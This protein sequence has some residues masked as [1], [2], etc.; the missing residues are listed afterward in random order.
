M[1]ASINE[2]IIRDGESMTKNRTPLDRHI[3]SSPAEFSRR[4]VNVKMVVVQ[5]KQ[6]YRNVPPVHT[7]LT[8][9]STFFQSYTIYQLE[10]KV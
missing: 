4:E 5:L 6:A 10:V 2:T 9:W 7:Q 3:W 1:S 8:N